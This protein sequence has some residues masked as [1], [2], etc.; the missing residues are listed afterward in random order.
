[1]RCSA[2]CSE[3]ASSLKA[4]STTSPTQPIN[5]KLSQR[6]RDPFKQCGLVAE[7]GLVKHTDDD[8]AKLYDKFL[9]VAAK[10]RSEDREQVLVRW[11]RK[12]KRKFEAN[13]SFDP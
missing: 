5:A 10:L 7:A 11:K 12:G 3:R 6:S 1:M 9:T 8:R 2:R 4:Q 13:S